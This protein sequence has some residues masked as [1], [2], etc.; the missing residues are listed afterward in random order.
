MT[1][2]IL[3]GGVN[4]IKPIVVKIWMNEDF[5][6]GTSVDNKSIFDNFFVIG[7]KC[8]SNREELRLTN[9]GTLRI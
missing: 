6:C 1:P 8:P 3:L 9:P 4:V 5:I 2:L 7:N